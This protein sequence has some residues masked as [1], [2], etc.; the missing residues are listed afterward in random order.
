MGGEV[1]NGFQERGL[2][3]GIDFR[4]AFLPGEQGEKF[5]INL[6]DHGCGVAVGDC[7]GDGHDDIYL[8]NQLGENKR[9]QQRHGTLTD[10]THKAGVWLG[11]RMRGPPGL[12]MITTAIKTYSLLVHAGAMCCFAIWVTARSRMSPRVGDTGLPTHK[13]P[14]FLTTT[15]TAS[16]IY[17]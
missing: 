12:I 13:P 3:S 8:L 6:Y 15:T 10:V 1:V 5:M 14:P 4:M 11:D 7:N 16:W 17:S 9:T 2:E